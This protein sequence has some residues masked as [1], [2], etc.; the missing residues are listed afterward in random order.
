MIELLTSW[1][2]LL[3]N[4]DHVGVTTQ[5]LNAA[6]EADLQTA[7]YKAAIDALTKAVADED[8]VYKRTQKD[9]AV[10]QLKLVDA[11]LDAYM[12]GL[13]S[14]VAGY[15]AFPD[16]ELSD[17]GKRFLQ[18]WKDY[19]FR[20]NDSYSAESAKVVNMFQEVEKMKDAAEALHVYEPFKKA[21][22]LALEVQRLLADRFSELAS[23]TVGE[24]KAARAETDQ[25]I[26]RFYMVLNGL[27]AF[28]NTSA[29]TELMR[30][31]RAIEDYARVYYLKGNASDGDNT[32]GGDTGGDA[33]GDN[34]VTPELPPLG[35]D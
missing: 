4:A 30:K 27:Q 23:R 7:G 17:K 33:G 21:N 3:K 11:E 16:A 28:E 15:A 5:I 20:T 34:G 12:K 6:K 26:K 25:V 10:D 14:I 35:G 19:D 8:E 29:L 2:T 18:V 13:R 9:W 22:E 32:P 24:M 31:L 1:I